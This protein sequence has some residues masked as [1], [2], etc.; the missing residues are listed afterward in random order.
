MP[1]A[2]TT[3]PVPPALS[4]QGRT[5]CVT[6]AGGFIASWLVKRLLEKGYTV[7]GTVRNPVDPKNDHL[8][9]LDGAADRLVLLRADLLDPES[10]VEAFSGCDGVFHAA[11]PVTD[12]PEMMIEPAIRGT[13]YVMTAAADTGVKRVV[14][15]SS[16]GTVYMNP[17]REPNKP[18]DDTCWSDLEYCKNT[19]NWYCYAKTVAE[20]GAWEVARKRGLDLIVVNPVLVLGPLLQPT[21]NASTDHVMKYLTGSA[22]TYVNAAQAYVHVQDVAEAHVRVYEAP[23]AHGRYIC[24]ESTLHRG[25]L[26]RILA[27]L[28]PEY[29]IPTKCKD[30][31]NPPVTGYKFTNQRLKDLGMDFVPVLQCLYETVKSLQEKGMLPVLPPKDD[32]DQQLHKS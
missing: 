11:S 29:P 17:Y 13:Q 6:G 23:Y 22:K 4:G 3:T 24:A 2:E 28:F 26:C 27:K 12:D 14:F 32:Q 5:V 1:T 8:R 18:V 16:I 21:V 10:L 25:E 20:Q 19:Q 7:R 9:A 30:D 31:V 15:T